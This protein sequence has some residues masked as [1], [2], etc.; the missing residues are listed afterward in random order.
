MDLSRVYL[1]LRSSVAWFGSLDL[2]Q[3][4]TNRVKE[5]LLVHDELVVEDGTFLVDILDEAG[6]QANV[7]DTSKT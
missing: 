1:P 4:M 5:S 2:R 7:L 6:M 3:Q